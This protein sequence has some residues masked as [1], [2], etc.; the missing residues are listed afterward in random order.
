MRA[1]KDALK[2]RS[3]LGETSAATRPRASDKEV[4]LKDL[5]SEIDLLG[6]E[7]VR[8]SAHGCRAV[9]LDWSTDDVDDDYEVEYEKAQME[10]LKAVHAELGIPEE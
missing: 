6:A 3:Q 7:G 9:L 5:L 2:E 8:L 4:E 1:Q 10:F